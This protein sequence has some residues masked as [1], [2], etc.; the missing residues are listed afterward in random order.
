[1]LIL[2]HHEASIA[3]PSLTAGGVVDCERVRLYRVVIEDSLGKRLDAD[4]YT[5]DRVNGL[6]TLADPLDLNSFTGPWTCKHSIADLRRVR[7]TDINGTLTLLQPL[8]YNFPA[9][10]TPARVSG[11]LY[12]GTLQARVSN[13][14][15]QSTWISVWSDTRIGDAP[16][17]QYLDSVYPI[18]VTNAGAY[19]DRYLIQFTSSTAFRLIGQNQ[20]ILAIGDITTDFEPISALTG[21]RMMFIDYRGWGLGWATGGCLRFNVHAGCYPVEAVR[22]VQPS[23][24][25]GLSDR[26]EILLTGN[27]DG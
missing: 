10:G 7:A 9:G 19:P 26:V 4:Q 16:L 23:D 13:L 5:V 2:I 6:V 15:A 1:M 11:M 21:E 25:T 17:Y 12:I 24:P 18:Q 3:L 20:G 22:A 27:V 8:S 14:F